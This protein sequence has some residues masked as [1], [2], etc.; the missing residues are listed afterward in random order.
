LNFGEAAFLN[1]LDKFSLKSPLVEIVAETLDSSGAERKRKKSFLVRQFQGTEED[2]ADCE[3]LVD[4]I[5][6][7]GL[8][9]CMNYYC[10]L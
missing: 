9:R 5:M 2:T 4:S 8:C 10:Y 6:N 3:D 7:C 1:G